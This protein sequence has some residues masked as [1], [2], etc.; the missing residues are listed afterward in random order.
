MYDYYNES[1]NY[2]QVVAGSMLIFWLSLTG[3][4]LTNIL[5]SPLDKW[6]VRK[7]L[8][9]KVI[10]AETE[11]YVL[12][13]FPGGIYHAGCRILNAKQ[14]RE[15]CLHILRKPIDTVTHNRRERAML[16]L[17]AIN[18]NEEST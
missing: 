1:L 18:E 8:K 7:K 14:A 10:L 15:H 5:L 3:L 4:V 16:F 17:A 12:Y 6:G 13:Y 2:L 11:D 9:G